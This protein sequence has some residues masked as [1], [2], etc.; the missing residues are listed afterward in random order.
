M[1]TLVRYKN[2]V[3]CTAHIAVLSRELRSLRQH[4]CI[5]TTDS[6]SIGIDYYQPTSTVSW[7]P[8]PQKIRFLSVMTSQLRSP[9]SGCAEA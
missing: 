6:F 3:F 9:I 4:L 1:I 8:V 2:S 5:L 7:P